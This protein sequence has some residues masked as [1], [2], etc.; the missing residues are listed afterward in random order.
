MKDP[1]LS[2]LLLAIEVKDSEMAMR[3]ATGHRRL[4][5]H[6]QKGRLRCAEW[7]PEEQKPEP[8]VLDRTQ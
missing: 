1:K 8:I 3:E 6:W 4:R 2:A 5:L 7:E